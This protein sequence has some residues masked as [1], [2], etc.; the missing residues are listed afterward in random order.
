VKLKKKQTCAKKKIDK[1][2]NYNLQNRDEAKRGRE[3]K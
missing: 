3:L 2:K 1:I